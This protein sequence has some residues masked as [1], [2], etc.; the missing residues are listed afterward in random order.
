VKHLIVELARCLALEGDSSM[1]ADGTG[2]KGPPLRAL[3]A[4][5]TLGMVGWG[6]YSSVT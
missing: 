1:V 4:G 2:D 6:N 5:E 3:V